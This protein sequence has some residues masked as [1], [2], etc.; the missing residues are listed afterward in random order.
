[1]PV[2]LYLFPSHLVKLLSLC[3]TLLLKHILG[4]ISTRHP[5]MGSSD[6]MGCIVVLEPG[7]SITWDG[8]AFSLSSSPRW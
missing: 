4:L 3:Y 7:F 2:Y 5:F 8:V 1:M 6:W